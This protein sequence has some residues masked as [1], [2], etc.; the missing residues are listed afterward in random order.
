MPRPEFNQHNQLYCNPVLKVLERQTLTF[1]DIYE[2]FAVNH[3][4]ENRKL[5]FKRF[6]WIESNSQRPKKYFGNGPNTQ[7]Q[8]G[9]F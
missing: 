8:N 9:L 4:L 6:V 5:E 3:S 2:F 1:Y 7:I